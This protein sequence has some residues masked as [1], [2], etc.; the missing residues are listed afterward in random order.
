MRCMAGIATSPFSASCGRNRL[1]LAKGMVENFFYEIRHY[2]SI[3][4]ANRTY[5]LTRS[6]PPFLTSMILAVYDAEDPSAQQKDT[7]W[8]QKAYDFAVTDYEQW[9]HPP[10]LAG[11][12]D[13]LVTTIMA[14]AQSRKSSAIPAIIIAARRNTSCCTTEQKILIWCLWI[15]IIPSNLW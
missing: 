5:Y 6:Q 8:L 4:N 13:Y 15:K 14:K 10:H 9:T 2:G 3:L 12:T 1:E 11:D 7:A